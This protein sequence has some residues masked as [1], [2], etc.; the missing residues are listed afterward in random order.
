MIIS[1]TKI[2]ICDLS[3][4]NCTNSFPFL[5]VFP[6]PDRS[7]KICVRSNGL[8]LPFKKNLHPFEW[9]GQLLAKTVNP[10]KRFDQPFAK[11]LSPFERFGKPFAKFLSSFK[12]FGQLFAKFLSPFKRFG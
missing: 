2:N 7:K 10:F 4:K 8:S 1:S 12:W 5:N 11:F 9:L 6:V 3:R